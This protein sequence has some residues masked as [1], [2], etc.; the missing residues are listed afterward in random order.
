MVKSLA[1][2]AFRCFEYAAAF[3]FIVSLAFVFEQ[4]LDKLVPWT[5]DYAAQDDL[6]A[7]LRKGCEDKQVT[8]RQADEMFLAYQDEQAGLQRQRTYILYA[9]SACVSAGFAVLVFKKYRSLRFRERFRG[10][11]FQPKV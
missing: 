3:L 5:Y 11:L 6:A 8:R 1:L 4:G 7:D 10:Y 9:V 2:G